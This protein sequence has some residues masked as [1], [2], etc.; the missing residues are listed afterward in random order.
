MI[1]RYRIFFSFIAIVFFISPLYGMKIKEIKYSGYSG[2]VDLS[3]ITYS[4]SQ[5]ISGEWIRRVSA[6]ITGLYHQNGYN[7]FYVEKVLV[8]EDGTVEFYF[9]ESPVSLVT[10]AGISDP[11]AGAVKRR[12]FSE[13]SPYNESVLKKNISVLKN[14]YGYRNI[15]V[16]L[17]RDSD[18]KIIINAEVIKS[19]GTFGLSVSGNTIYG[20]APEI[21]WLVLRGRDF[22]SISLSSSLGQRDARSSDAGVIYKKA[23]S[24]WDLLTSL[25][26]GERRDYLNDYSLYENRSVSPGFSAYYSGSLFKTGLFLRGN[27]YNLENYGAVTRSKEY[28]VFSGLG[29]VYDN[30][31]FVIDRSERKSCILEISG[32]WNSL[33][34]NPDMRINSEARFS[35]TIFRRMSLIIKNYFFMTTEQE[36]L[37]LEYVFNNSL[38]GR[39][40]DY[41][42]SDFK[43]SAGIELE[44][45]IYP[46]LFYMGPVFYYGIY[47]SNSDYERAS[48]AGLNISFDLTG[49]FFNAAYIYDLSG[50]TREGVLLFSLSGSF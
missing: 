27:Y 35:F 15:N 13:G 12:I 31:S 38:P 41:T 17:E 44:F 7:A 4:S 47:R 46:S 25:L 36:R 39:E 9:N 8:K 3:D 21:T 6:E 28:D 45:E 20:A 43:N 14:E 29:F 5:E 19:R 24:R 18:G 34:E 37:F 1:I 30:T 48:S 16:I 33:E 42:V 23:F 2:I 49:A 40:D 26:L 50:S 32:G 22:F 11:E 10:V